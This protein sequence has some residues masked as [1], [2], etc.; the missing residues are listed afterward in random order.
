M[1]D[2]VAIEQVA[3]IGTAIGTILLVYLF[4]VA[5]KQM[6]E[7][8]K[9]SRIQ[10]THRFRPWIGPSSSI[11]QIATIEGR[12]QFSITLKNYGELPSSNVT[13]VY[14]MKNQPLTRN[15]LKENNSSNFNL[16]P[17]LPNMEKHYWFF[18]ESDAI[19]N[20][21]K[22]SIPIFISLYFSYEYAA[23]KS[24]YGMISQYDSAVDRFVHK[25]M[26]VD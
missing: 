21:K 7:T 22:S 16:G 13:A 10:S 19:Q 2:L 26:W 3:S 12:Q 8:V 17:L 25:D 4:W 15:S 5:L 11:E 20:A 6:E 1:V 14:T 18:I 9:L 23:G 24:G